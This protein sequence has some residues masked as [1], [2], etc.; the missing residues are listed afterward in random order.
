MELIEK[1]WQQ[2]EEQSEYRSWKQ[3]VTEQEN[4]SVF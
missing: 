2:T 3:R 1:Y 4:I